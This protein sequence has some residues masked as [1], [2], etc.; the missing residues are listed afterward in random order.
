VAT[1]FLHRSADLVARTA[2]LV[3]RTGE[4]ARYEEIAR[5]ALRAWRSHYIAADGSLTPDTQATYVR[6]LAWGLLPH[7]LRRPAADRLAALVRSA[8]TH[9]DTGFL[10]TPDLLPVLADHGHLDL[11]YELLLQRT[12]PSWLG[13]L[14]RGATTVWE[15]WEGISEDGEAQG[16]LN[17]YSKGAV[18]SFLHTRTAGISPLEPGYRRFRVA[19]RPGGGLRSVEGVHQSPYGRI[20]SA[21]Q[22]ASGGVFHLEVTVPAGTNAEID[23]P[24]GSRTGVGPG[25]HEFLVPCP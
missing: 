1:A 19:P 3:D 13:M 6:A 5:G 7:E 4:A 24:D 18:I 11:A 17:H 14:D 23:L 20:R 8:G 10:S 12:T 21:W 16:S 15:S 25:S 2:R 22:L 9:L